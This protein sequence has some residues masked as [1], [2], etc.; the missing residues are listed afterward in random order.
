[1]I[2]SA[3]SRGAAGG[4]TQQSARGQSQGSLRTGFRCLL[5]PLAGLALLQV[6]F[7]VEPVPAPATQKVE[8]VG[9]GD[10]SEETRDLTAAK[11]VVSRQDIERFADT[12]L[13]A[14]LQ[15]VRGLTIET[16]G[17]GKATVRLRGLGQGYTQI[18]LNGEPVSS[19]FSLDSIAPSMIERIEVI[20]VG[21]VD[22][23]M[24]GISGT[25]NIVLKSVQRLR[26]SDLSTTVSR[27]SGR[28]SVAIDGAWFDVV[29][30]T[31]Y[32]VNGSAGTTRGLV[33]STIEQT[34]LNWFFRVLCG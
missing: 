31:R 29:G 5:V 28:P 3:G 1:M 16:D 26:R 17:S 32:A 8:I 34:S 20:R 33:Q 18:L 21:S 25:I 12:R 22:V 10:A 4:G 23:S 27:E 14:I 19:D 15:R 13:T 9:T 2:G 6:A 7:A 11:S 30:D 24:A